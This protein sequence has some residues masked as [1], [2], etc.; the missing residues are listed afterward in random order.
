MGAG[1][2]GAG[3]VLVAAGV[4][5]ICISLAVAAWAIGV[6][7]EAT[8]AATTFSASASAFAIAKVARYFGCPVSAN[9]IGGSLRHLAHVAILFNQASKGT[10]AR[11]VSAA[12][13]VGRSMVVGT[14]CVKFMRRP[15]WG[16]NHR[17]WPQKLWAVVWFLGKLVLPV[18]LTLC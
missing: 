11:G 18:C 1:V 5:Q 3:A 9:Y 15:L 10:D 4:M 17:F 14:V 16:Y 13:E 6:S 8:G 7:T 2:A 12:G